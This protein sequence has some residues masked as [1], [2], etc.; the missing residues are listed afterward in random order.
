MLRRR[1]ILIQLYAHRL[2][3]DLEPPPSLFYLLS[4]VN[5]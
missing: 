5:F 3:I 1:A 2:T 4:I